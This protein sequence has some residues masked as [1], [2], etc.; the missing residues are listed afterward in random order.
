MRLRMAIRARSCTSYILLVACLIVSLPISRV[1]HQNINHNDD[2]PAKEKDMFPL[3]TGGKF[4]VC[5]GNTLTE[6]LPGAHNCPGS[7]IGSI[8]KRMGKQV[9]GMI[10]HDG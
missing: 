4:R 7:I 10:S 6:R 5:T 2:S 1:I 8:E 9:R 3:I